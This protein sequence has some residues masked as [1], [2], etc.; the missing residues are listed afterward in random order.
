ML[1]QVSLKGE[2]VTIP[3]I[4]AQDLYDWLLARLLRQHRERT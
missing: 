3:A 2:K 1:E 4:P